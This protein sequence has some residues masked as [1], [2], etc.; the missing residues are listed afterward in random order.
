ME[1][2][3][4]LFLGFTVVLITVIFTMTGC[5]I[6]EDATFPSEF[7]GT[8]ERAF[9]SSYTN[10]LTFTSDT[11]KASNQS[12]HWILVSI[13]GDSYTIEQSDDREHKTTA[14]IKLIGGNLEITEEY[15]GNSQDNWNGKWKKY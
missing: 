8:W 12:A 15:Q 11:L 10:K 2:K 7:R 9:E 3:Q 6:P 14:V 5:D 1:K 4:K 13:S